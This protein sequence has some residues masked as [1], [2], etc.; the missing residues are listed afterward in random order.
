[1]FA[2]LLMLR[3]VLSRRGGS[4]V[5]ILGPKIPEPSLRSFCSLSQSNYFIMGCKLFEKHIELSVQTHK[6]CSMFYCWNEKKDLFIR[7]FIIKL[8]I[9][10]CILKYMSEEQDRH[11]ELSVYIFYQRREKC[12]LSYRTLYKEKNSAICLTKKKNTMSLQL[13]S[14]YLALTWDNMPI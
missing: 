3:L 10:I 1:M 2:E 13:R 9:I 8:V 6:F 4:L 11:T 5:H 12:W 14:W 7:I